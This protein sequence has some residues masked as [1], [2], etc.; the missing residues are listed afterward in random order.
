MPNAPQ[1]GGLNGG[2]IHMMWRCPKCHRYWG[3]VIDPMNSIFGVTL[4][5]NP[6]TCILGYIWEE[7]IANRRQTTL[8]RCLFLAHKLIATKWLAISPPTHT[9]WIKKVDNIIRK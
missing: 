2:L 6:I 4:E 9:E 3:E 7:G 1:C 5:L 8:I